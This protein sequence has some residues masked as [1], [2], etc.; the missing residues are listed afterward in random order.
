MNDDEGDLIA[1]PHNIL[2]RWGKYFSQPFNE[3]W[4]SDVRQ[5]VINTPGSL[6]LEPSASEFVLAIVKLK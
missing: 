5:I 4:F 6:V 3:H 1:Y 2:A